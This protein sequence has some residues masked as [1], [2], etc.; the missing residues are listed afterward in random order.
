MKRA[1][2]AIAG[3]LAIPFVMAGGVA[4]GNPVSPD[5]RVSFVVVPDGGRPR[6]A[7][8]QYSSIGPVS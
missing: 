5:T 4:R 2:G 1:I 7:G 3:L 6:I 8:I